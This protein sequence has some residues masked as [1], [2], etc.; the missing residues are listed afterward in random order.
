M[1]HFVGIRSFLVGLLL[2]V[3]VLLNHCPKSCHKLQNLKKQP[4]DKEP[5]KSV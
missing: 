4:V 3:F 5:T 1:L 2:K